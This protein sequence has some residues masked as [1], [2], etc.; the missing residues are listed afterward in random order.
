LIFLPRCLISGMYPA[1]KAGPA[2]ADPGLMALF[3]ASKQ[4]A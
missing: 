1:E 4:R 3:W 2:G